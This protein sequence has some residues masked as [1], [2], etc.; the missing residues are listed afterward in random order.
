MEATLFSIQIDFNRAQTQAAQIEQI[1]NGIESLVK[2]DMENYMSGVE[3]NWKGGNAA[4]Y[5]KKGRRL[6]QE[7]EKSAAELK[8]TAQTIRK[9]AQNTYNAEKKAIMAARVRTYGE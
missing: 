3:A 7:L 9:V 8:K 4:L 5:I 6:E 2:Q 1:A